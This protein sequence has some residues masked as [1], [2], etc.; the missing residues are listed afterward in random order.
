M[1]EMNFQGIPM[2]VVK[3][4]LTWGKLARWDK[5]YVPKNHGYD[6]KY[7]FEESCSM[8][9]ARYAYAFHYRKTVPQFRTYGACY[10]WTEASLKATQKAL[11][12]AGKIRV[13]VLLLQAGADSMVKLSG[14]DCLVERSSFVHLIRFS[15]AKHEL[16]NGT[17]EIREKFYKEIFLFLKA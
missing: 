13:P 4:L 2:P 6:G 7:E 16:F 15:G 17:D 1:L 8:S 9:R 10:K 3:L 12:D 14:Q 5:R 11:K